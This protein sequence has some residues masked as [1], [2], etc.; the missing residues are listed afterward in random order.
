MEDLAAALQ[1]DIEALREQ[2]PAA[3]R[4]M[5]IACCQ[6]GELERCE[7]AIADGVVG[8]TFR[9]FC[10]NTAEFERALSGKKL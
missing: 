3:V 1:V 9:A 6:C 10:P 8:G 5:E 2:N 7:K 4:E